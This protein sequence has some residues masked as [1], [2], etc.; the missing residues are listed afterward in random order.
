V[1][2]ETQ[3]IEKK[4]TLRW[5]GAELLEVPA[6][7][8]KN[9]LNYVH[10]A[11]RLAT[12]I[13]EEAAQTKSGLNVLYADQWSNPANRRAHAETTGPE[14]REKHS[15]KELSLQSPIFTLSN[16]F[17]RTLL[18]ISSKCTIWIFFA[19]FVAFL[20]FLFLLPPP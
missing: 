6:V 15:E 1:I 10:V 4:N 8:F 17:S 7:P 11:E 19:F 16:S 18:L 14:V 9:P 13:K 2:A 5:G 12:Q 3:S 20:L